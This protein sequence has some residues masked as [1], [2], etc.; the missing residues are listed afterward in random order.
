MAPVPNRTQGWQITGK[1]SG[2]EMMAW[3]TKISEGSAGGSAGP[4]GGSSDADLFYVGVSKDV[5]P[6][7]NLQLGQ[8]FLYLA[9]QVM[10]HLL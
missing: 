9:I 6:N 10:I 8:V 7:L 4:W 2:M 5:N 1:V 3:T